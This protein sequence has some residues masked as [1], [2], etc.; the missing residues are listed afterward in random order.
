MNADRCVSGSP[1][2]G[3]GSALDAV[4]VV[5]LRAAVARVVNLQAVVQEVQ[6]LLGLLTLTHGVRVQNLQETSQLGSRNRGPTFYNS[7][8]T[9]QVMVLFSLMSAAKLCLIQLLSR[10]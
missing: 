8:P 9:N 5:Q 2:L 10:Q 4:V 1:E 3:F 7:C 6:V